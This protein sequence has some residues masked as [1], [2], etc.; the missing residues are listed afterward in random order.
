MLGLRWRQVASLVAATVCLSSVCCHGFGIH[1]NNGGAF[2]PPSLMPSEKCSADG[3]QSDW[4]AQS[5]QLC[6]VQKMT[7][8]KCINSL[9]MDGRLKSSSTDESEQS[10]LAVESTISLNDDDGSL[11]Q[12][13]TAADSNGAGNEY[14]FYDEATIYVRAGSGGQG[15][16][17]FYTAGNT[18][19]VG[20][21]QRGKANGGDGGKGGDVYLE[22]DPSLNTVAYLNYVGYRPN[23]FGGGGGA[24]VGGGATTVGASSGRKEWAKSF[25]AEKGGDG[26]WGFKNA[27]NA[28]DVYIKVP[29]GT[30]V[31]EEVEIVDLETGET[32]IIY[33][34]LGEVRLQ[35]RSTTGDVSVMDEAAMKA[36]P[37][38][39]VA[40]G[41]EGGEGN[42]GTGAGKASGGRG[43]KR[44]RIPPEGGERKRLKLTLKVVAD[45]ALVGVPNAGKSTLLAAVTRAKPKIANYPFTTVIPNLGVWIPTPPKHQYQQYNSGG[46]SNDVNADNTS[47][48]LCDV[49]GLIEGAAEG[50]GL[51]H[52]FLRHVER[53]HVIL[54]IVDCTSEDPVAD[55]E[56]L[57]AELT[58]YGSGALITKPQVVV[59]NKSD[60]WYYDYSENDHAEGIS[61]VSDG[62]EIVRPPKYSKEELQ[63]RLRE[64]MPH[65]RLMF[66]S[67]GSKDGVEDLMLRL[68]TFVGKVKEANAVPVDQ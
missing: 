62:T 41:G 47:L 54:H 55:F 4:R 61:S 43:V 45:V 64:S 25:K 19:A 5:L 11:G 42:G 8:V 21:G 3:C 10:D 15:G 30:I 22:V 51:G 63:E 26:D 65:S 17:K 68:A 50:V 39:L 1:I 16:T 67:A 18:A 58:R 2:S 46:G 13:S 49:P 60:A 12:S 20:K 32:S 9:K 53:C 59:V 14:S 40:R 37:M 7:N 38:L 31:E 29:S 28:E 6:R 24:A 56:M 33:R 66:M 57:N 52:A 34:P 36:E 44:A 23:A 27:K 48:V 35:A